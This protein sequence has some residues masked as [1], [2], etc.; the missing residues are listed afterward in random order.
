MKK[1]TA[2]GK[3]KPLTAFGRN[4]QARDGLNYYCKPCASRR[5]RAW[6]KAHPQ[7]VR[8]SMNRYRAKL[9]QLNATRDPYDAETAA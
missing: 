9:R 5:Q 4:Q 7:S 2:C 3:Q 8:A 1:C 6:A